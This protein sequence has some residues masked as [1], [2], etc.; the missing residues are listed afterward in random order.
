MLK[1]NLF[2]VYHLYNSISDFSFSY[3]IK[4]NC[5]TYLSTFYFLE[6]YLLNLNIVSSLSLFFYIYLTIWLVYFLLT[7]IHMQIYIFLFFVLYLGNKML[8]KI[9][10]NPLKLSNLSNLFFQFIFLFSFK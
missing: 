1:I 3:H 2:H 7:F 8:L 4:Q 10:N 6:N 9:P 5:I